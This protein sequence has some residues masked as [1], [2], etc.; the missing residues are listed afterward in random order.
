MISTGGSGQT[1]Q[2]RAAAVGTDAVGAAASGSSAAAGSTGRPG[3][4]PRRRPSS[5]RR[6][7]H[8]HNTA[9][10]RVVPARATAL[11]AAAAAQYAHS[12][13]LRPL[14]TLLT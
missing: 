9:A 10:I 4:R 11:R 13:K 14:T 1:E 5:S 7:A 6:G 8:S 3:R 2:I 12:S